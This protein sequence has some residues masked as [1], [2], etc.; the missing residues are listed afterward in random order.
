MTLV[1]TSIWIDHLR[2]GSDQLAALLEA[3]MVLV[4]PFI[5]GELACG[6]LKNRDQ[7]IA[8]M[9]RLPQAI[10]ASDSEALQ[11]IDAQ[12]LM[13]AGVGYIDVHLLAS[14]ALTPGAEIWTRDKTLAGIAARFTN[15]H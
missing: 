12:Q 11:F 15:L 5:I 14:A 8:E 13:G 7:V 10:V 9:Q 1:D 4:H 2:R 3:N 6:N